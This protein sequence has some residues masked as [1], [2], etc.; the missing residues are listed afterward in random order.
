MKKIITKSV[1][2]ITVLAIMFTLAMPAAAQAKS[3]PKLNKTKISLNVNK[4]YQLK[5]TGTSKKATWKT[6]N[7]KVAAVSKTGMVTAKKKGTAIITAKVSKKIY[8]CKVTV[9]DT[10]KKNS[11]KDE[12]TEEETEEPK[13]TAIHPIKKDKDGY[14][15]GPRWQC[16]CGVPI[17]ADIDGEWERHVWFFCEAGTDSPQ[18][19][20]KIPIKKYEYPTICCSCGLCFRTDFES[21]K[22]GQTMHD[23]AWS[24]YEYA[25]HGQPGHIHEDPPSNGGH[26]TGPIC[27]EYEKHDNCPYH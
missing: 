8:K 15:E 11:E 23:A 21:G 4:S 7:K 17:H 10:R 6:S 12:A 18:D 22:D 20:Q 2:V 24:F 19:H 5:V 14:F 27:P 9:K 1:T 13:N 25:T 3:A 16:T 26:S